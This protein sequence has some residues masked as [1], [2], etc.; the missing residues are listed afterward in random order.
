MGMACSVD[1]KD[2]NIIFIYIYYYIHTLDS[3]IFLICSEKPNQNHLSE[4]PCNAGEIQP[5]LTFPF[6][7]E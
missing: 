4:L 5:S 2:N 7:A 6:P 3:C 1:F